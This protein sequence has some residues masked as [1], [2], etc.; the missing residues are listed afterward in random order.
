MNFQ[1]LK[2]NELPLFNLGDYLIWA[3][4]MIAFFGVCLTVIIRFALCVKRA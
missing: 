2:V 3:I 4:R 1:Y